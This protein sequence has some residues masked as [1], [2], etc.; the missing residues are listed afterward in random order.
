MRRPASRGYGPGMGRSDDA[1]GVVL[2]ALS[3]AIDTIATEPALDRVLSKLAEG[4]RRLARAR[5]AA[6]GIPAPEGDA[7][8]RFVTVGMS[9]ELIER[10]GPLPRTHGMLGAMLTETRPFRHRRHH[11]GPRF[12]GWW[13]SAHP[14]CAP[15]SEC[16][17]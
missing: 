9:D 17:W 11:P 5:Y 16:R 1:A 14:R 8:D 4:A 12:R 3:E 7:F 6:I 2:T 10:L 15:S 13:P